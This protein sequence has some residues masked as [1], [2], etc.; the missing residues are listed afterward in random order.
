M[1]VIFPKPCWPYLTAEQKKR[2]GD[3]VLN[4]RQSVDYN[5]RHHLLAR[6]KCDSERSARKLAKECFFMVVVE[7]SDGESDVAYD[8]RSFVDPVTNRINLEPVIDRL[9]GV[10]LLKRKPEEQERISE[11]DEQ[12]EMMD[13]EEKAQVIPAISRR[14]I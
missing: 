9:Q 14:E 11:E 4:M 8:L 13:E 1:H 10:V 6:G 3:L 7:D 5:L 12:D 2:S